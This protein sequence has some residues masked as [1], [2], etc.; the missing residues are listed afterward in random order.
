MTNIF[1]SIR[2][3]I[4]DS[5]LPAIVILKMEV[6]F[7]SATNRAGVKTC[8][9]RLH[10]KSQRAKGFQGVNLLQDEL[11]NMHVWKLLSKG[12][13]STPRKC[14]VAILPS[15][16]RGLQAVF[17]PKLSKNEE[18]IGVL[19]CVWKSEVFQILQKNG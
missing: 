3:S 18:T 19:N 11:Q 2:P 12:T 17:S 9:N 8:E 13:I 6:R 7:A 4:E 15:G 14:S 1:L 16:I 5:T 10:T